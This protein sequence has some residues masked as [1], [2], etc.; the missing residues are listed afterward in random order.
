MDEEWAGYLVTEG[1]VE[2]PGSGWV[3]VEADVSCHRREM[4]R[5][6]KHQII[7]NHTPCHGVE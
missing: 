2:Y 1:M 6:E 7:G 4:G 3:G 5:D